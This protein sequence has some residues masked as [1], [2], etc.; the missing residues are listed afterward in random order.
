MNKSTFTVQKMDCPSEEQMIR[1]KLDPVEQ[2]RHLAFDIS[3]RK[4]EVYHTGESDEIHQAIRQLDL[5]DKLEET[6]QAALPL[7]SDDSHQRNILWW[8]L[9]INFCFFIIEMTTGWISASMGLIADSLDM[10]AD[11]LVYALSLFAVGTSV[12]RKKK[13]A[14]ISGYLQMGLALLGFAEVIRRFF[15]SSET[16]LFKWMIIVSVFA[17][18]GN[19][20]SLLLI[21]KAKS[22]EAHMQASAIFTS[23]DIIVNGGV[24]VAGVLVYFLDSKWPDLIIG[25]IVFSF[26]M[27]GALRIL[28]LSK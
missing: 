12:S 28:K 23:N 13:V 21:N 16:P 24:I 4:L 26:V 1:M 17:L 11:A 18:A 14:G 9:G 15:S 6:T 3:N 20:V 22:E 7:T 8:V 19:L 2:V 10:L 5:N 27:R 25:G